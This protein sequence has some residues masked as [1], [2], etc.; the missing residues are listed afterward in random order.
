MCLGRPGETQRWWWRL[1]WIRDAFGR[2]RADETLS[3]IEFRRRR[4]AHQ[5][6]R[7]PRVADTSNTNSSG[8]AAGVAKIYADFAR[9]IAP[10]PTGPS[11]E[12]AK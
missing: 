1:R 2:H 3:P 11:T 4:E 7:P 12:V 9:R 5:L 10:R 8:E 6:A